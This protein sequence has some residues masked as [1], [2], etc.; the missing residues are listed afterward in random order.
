MRNT[1]LVKFWTWQIF[2]S[3]F[4]FRPWLLICFVSKTLVRL[5]HDRCPFVFKKGHG[6]FTEVRISK[7]DISTSFDLERPQSDYHGTIQFLPWVLKS[8]RFWNSVCKIFLPMIWIF[9][10]GEGDWIEFR[11]LFKIFSTL[12]VSSQAEF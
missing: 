4:L 12:L 9:T 7:F 2:L 3:H 6:S 10:E 5:K 1:N 11:L 8:F